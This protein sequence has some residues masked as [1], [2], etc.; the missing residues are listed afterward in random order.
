M[1]KARL[2]F[3]KMTRREK[4]SWNAIILGLLEE[5]SFFHLRKCEH[6]V[7]PDVITMISLISACESLVDGRLGREIHRIY[8]C[9]GD[10]G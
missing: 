3:N 2:L 4:I 5:I 9:D 1:P 7:D 10:I 6:W 8:D